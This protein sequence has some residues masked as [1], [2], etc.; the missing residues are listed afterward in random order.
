MNTD[1]IIVGSGII[2]MTLALT[3]SKNNKKVVIIERTALNH[4]ACVDI[5]DNILPNS[6]CITPTRNITNRVKKY[7]PR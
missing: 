6:Q 7:P 5:G 2:G 3:L 4:I 1:A